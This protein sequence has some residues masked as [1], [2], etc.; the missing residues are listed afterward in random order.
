MESSE[1]V[2][3]WIQS[4][5]TEEG[6]VLELGP[7]SLRTAGAAGKTTLSLVSRTKSVVPSESI[8]MDGSHGHIMA[9]CWC[10]SV[11]LVCREIFYQCLPLTKELVVVSSIP[12]ITGWWSYLPPYPGCSVPNLPSPVHCY[13]QFSLRYSGVHSISTLYILS[14]KVYIV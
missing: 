4:I 12:P 8:P 6:A 3:G 14:C 13:Q 1:R 11:I 10:R 9:L 5:H 7:R 2:G